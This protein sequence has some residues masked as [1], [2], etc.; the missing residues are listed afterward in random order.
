VPVDPSH[1]CCSHVVE[2]DSSYA[3]TRGACAAAGCRS[4]LPPPML[5]WPICTAAACSKSTVC[6]MC[7]V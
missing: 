5:T 4:L 6:C 2:R 7:P 3:G 1:A